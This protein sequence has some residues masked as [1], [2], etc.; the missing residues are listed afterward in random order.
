MIYKR[1]SEQ[2]LISTVLFIKVVWSNMTELSAY[3]S[4]VYTLYISSLTGKEYHTVK[5]Y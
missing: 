1:I 2:R 3:L 5:Q 4:V